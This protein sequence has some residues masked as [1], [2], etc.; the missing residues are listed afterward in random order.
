MTPVPSIAA[1]NVETIPPPKNELFKSDE[2]M[3]NTF[4]EAIRYLKK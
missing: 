3:E 4:E 2:V 1:D